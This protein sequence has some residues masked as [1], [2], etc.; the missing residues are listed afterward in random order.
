MKK[1]L[2]TILCLMIGIFIYLQVPKQ[3][4]ISP[5]SESLEPTISIFIEE[6]DSYDLEYEYVEKI[7]IPFIELG[8]MDNGRTYLCR[9]IQKIFWPPS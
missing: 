9:G 8:Y 3:K 1:Y 2:I 6:T 7:I 4:K 5:P